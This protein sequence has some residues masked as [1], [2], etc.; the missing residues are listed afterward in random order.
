VAQRDSVSRQLEQAQ[1]RFEVGLI[2]ITDVQ[3]SQAGYDDS[4]AAEIQGQRLLANSYEQ[5][6]EII[7]EVVMELAAPGDDL[8]LV[9]PDP[10][11]PEQWV[12][13]ALAQNLTLV[14]SRLAAEVAEYD[15]EIQKGTRLP[16]VNL[17]ASYTDSSSN[18]ATT[19]HFD[20][21]L[22]D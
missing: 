20:P 18:R 6:R 1:R 17:Q 19:L 14:S 15:I 8:P 7:G 12:R 9:S 3:Q 2:A 22:G 13:T 5:L 16:T 21:P 10:A 4:V 11:S